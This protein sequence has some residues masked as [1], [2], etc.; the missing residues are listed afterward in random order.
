MDVELGLWPLPATEVHPSL[1]LVNERAI[2]HHPD[3]VGCLGRVPI[4]VVLHQLHDDGLAQH[5]HLVLLIVLAPGR[6]N[7]TELTRILLTELLALRVATPEGLEP[8]GPTVL[9]PKICEPAVQAELLGQ[10]SALLATNAE[11]LHRNTEARHR[12]AA[13]PQVATAVAGLTEELLSAIA[14]VAVAGLT[15]CHLVD[16]Q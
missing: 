13:P 6:L 12:A 15:V 8:G 3:V 9:L 4:C 11:V 10:V 7:D 1:I 2:L 16:G 14:L 5:V